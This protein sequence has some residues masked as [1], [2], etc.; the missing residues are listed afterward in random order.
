MQRSVSLTLR[1]PR[2]AAALSHPYRCVGPALLRLLPLLLARLALL[3]LSPLLL[4]RLSPLCLLPLLLARLSLLRLLLPLGV[5]PS[6]RLLTVGPHR[7]LLAFCPRLLRLLARGAGGSLLLLRTPSLRALLTLGPPGFCLALARCPL[8][9]RCLTDRALLPLFHRLPLLHFAL[10]HLALLR[11]PSPLLG[12]ATFALLCQLTRALP[13]LLLA[14]GPLGLRLPLLGPPTAG[15]R[16]L[17]GLRPTLLHLPAITH[18]V[19]TR[20]FDPPLRLGPALLRLT[21]RLQ[22]VV[23]RAEV[24]LKE[25]DA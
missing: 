4:T 25:T 1:P 6:P 14:I 16:T 10:L 19:M 2:L 20:P 24:A 18:P 7:G 11:R 15:F 9:R 5:L 13:V 17:F 22:D 3:R 21:Q 8:P 12:R 23:A